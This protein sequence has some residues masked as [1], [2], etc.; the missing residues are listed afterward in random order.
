[1]AGTFDED[2]VRVKLDGQEVPIAETYR[3]RCGVL[4]VPADFEMVTGHGGIFADLSAAFPPRTPFELLVGDKSVQVGETKGPALVNGSTTMR[5]AGRDFMGRLVKGQILSEQTFA[6]KTYEQLTLRAMD[7]VSLG[8]RLL[9]T[10]NTANRKA[11]TGKTVVEFEKKTEDAQTDVG[12]TEGQQRLV[13]RTIKG[14]VGTTWFE[15][16][17]QQYRRVGLFLWADHGGNFVLSR[18]NGAQ[19]AIAR[20]I[21]KR[22][23]PRNEVSVLGEPSFEHD[24]T[25][26]YSECI[27]L[28]R[29]GGGKYGRGK[30]LERYID[31]EMVTILNPDPADRQDGGKY[32]EPLIIRDPHIRTESQARLLA[33]RKIAESRRNAWRLTYRVGGHSAPALRGGGRIVW[34]P[35]TVVEVDDDELGLKGVMYVESV[36]FARS[37]ETT[38][39]LHLMRID[40]LVFAEE[41][42]EAM[43]KRAKLVPRRGVTTVERR[44]G[45]RHGQEEAAENLA[46]WVRAPQFIPGEKK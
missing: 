3:V 45:V 20:I 24:T 25:N 15:F 6:E 26:R 33:R 30:I 1:V 31:E 32:R 4:E 35:D 41:P 42:D 17:N 16:L 40:D 5:I 12:T 46:M 22:N 10:D 29:G 34:Q 23:Q 11:I 27:V 19:S 13:Y 18:P 9:F 38:T 43:K 36:T 21:R 7:A 14:D 8:D 28:G 2:P 37:P 44:L 39:E